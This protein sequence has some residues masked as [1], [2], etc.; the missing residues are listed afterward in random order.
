MRAARPSIFTRAPWLKKS[1]EGFYPRN[2]NCTSTG[3]QTGPFSSLLHLDV[4]PQSVRPFR[5]L[6]GQR[7]IGSRFLFDA[8]THVRAVSCLLQELSR[9]TPRSCPP[10]RGG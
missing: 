7:L 5:F 10:I 2:S 4:L 8:L 6:S 3:D 9:G 1:P